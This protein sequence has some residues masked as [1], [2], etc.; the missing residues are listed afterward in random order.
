MMVDVKVITRRFGSIIAHHVSV[1]VLL[2]K[3]DMTKHHMSYE[4]WI[5][6]GD[7]FYLLPIWII[8]WSQSW[9]LQLLMHVI[10]TLWLHCHMQIPFQVVLKLPAIRI[11]S[12]E[13]LL[14]Y[15]TCPLPPLWNTTSLL[16]HYKISIKA[17]QFADSRSC[18]Q[19]F[20]NDVC[21]LTKIIVY[22]LYYQSIEKYNSLST[23]LLVIIMI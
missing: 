12:T 11:L 9:L 7:H 5:E 3:V 20:I 13:F 6:D 4:Q 1:T 14:C 18:G 2:H 17:V 22:W 15:A 10:R 16:N 23:I 8:V 19:I 21:G